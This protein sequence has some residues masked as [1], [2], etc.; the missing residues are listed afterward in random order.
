MYVGGRN[1]QN[2]NQQLIAL[3]RSAFRAFD[4][5]RIA[6][7]GLKS[8]RTCS[9]WKRRHRSGRYPCT[10]Q[11][12]QSCCTVPFHSETESNLMKQAETFENVQQSFEV[13]DST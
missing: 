9:P 8:S 6:G 2:L 4:I 13:I 12:G 1:E 7:Q 11:H 5:S 3:H 10:E